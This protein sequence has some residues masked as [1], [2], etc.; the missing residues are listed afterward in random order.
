MFKSIVLTLICC[1]CL[2]VNEYGFVHRIST[3][4]KSKNK[5]KWCYYHLQTPPSKTI[6]VVGFN[7]PCHKSL[8]H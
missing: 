3:V 7:L 8:K 4:K 1:L 2:A 5:H 6:S